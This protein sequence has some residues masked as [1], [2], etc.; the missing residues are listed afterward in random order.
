MSDGWAS[1]PAGSRV[2]ISDSTPN[3][4]S[5]PSWGSPSNC[6]WLKSAPALSPSPWVVPEG[7]PESL[8]ALPSPSSL[9]PATAANRQI[10]RTSASRR[11]TDDLCT[12]HLSG[13]VI[14]VTLIDVAY[15]RSRGL[16]PVLRC[17]R[18]PQGG[19]D[20]RRGG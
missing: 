5:P 3:T 6:A 15:P 9:L 19:H 1:A 11:R 17:G 14:L 12:L 2:A 20:R 18:G 7:L 16:T 4:I 10:P 13:G 8:G